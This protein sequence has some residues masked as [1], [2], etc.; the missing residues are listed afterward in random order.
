MVINEFTV[1]Q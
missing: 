1:T